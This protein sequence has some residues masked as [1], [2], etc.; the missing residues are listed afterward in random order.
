MA[1]CSSRTAPRW[2]GEPKAAVSAL[3][4]QPPP[5]TIAQLDHTVWTVCDGAPMGVI[6]LAQAADG[7][8]WIS[9]TTG[10][11]QFD[12]ARLEPFE[13][14]TGQAQR[15]WS[16]SVLLALPD[17]ALW[18]GYHQGGVSSLVRGWLTSWP[19]GEGLPSGTVTAFARD[20]GGRKAA[21]S[22]TYGMGGGKGGAKRGVLCSSVVLD[23]DSVK[24]SKL[25]SIKTL[26]R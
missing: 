9:T 10:L 1:T 13:P 23:R 2:Y 15:S 24:R 26:P 17:G 3:R 5:P 18:I 6:A 22:G 8:L 4:A 16:V 20:W 25:R 11:Y 14:G 12:G 19:P 7:L 21:S